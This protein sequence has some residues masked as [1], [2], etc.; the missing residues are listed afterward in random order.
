MPMPYW[1]DGGPH[2]IWMAISWIVV[3][4]LFGLLVWALFGIGRSYPVSR[5]DQSP[6]AIL[7]RRYAAGEIDTEEYERRLET[8]RKTKDAA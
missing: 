1:F 4:G 6:E 8:L 3:I 7:R 2:I 5:S